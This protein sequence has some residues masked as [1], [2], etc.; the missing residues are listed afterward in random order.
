[1]S[2]Q[3][4]V[5]QFSDQ[6]FLQINNFDT[7]YIECNGRFHN[8]RNCNFDLVEISIVIAKVR[9]RTVITRYHRRDNCE[10]R[11]RLIR[12]RFEKNCNLNE[13]CDV[14]MVIG[15]RFR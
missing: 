15:I 8:N 1:M 14:R 13:I 2:Y 9:T 10:S 6:E 11:G 12:D 7:L 5:T 3:T 4:Y